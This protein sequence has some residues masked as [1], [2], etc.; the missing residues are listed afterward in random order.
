LLRP[1]G[2]EFH[3]MGQIIEH[4]G[5]RQPGW[6]A[7]GKMTDRIRRYR[8]DLWEL[9]FDAGWEVSADAALAHG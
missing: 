6:A 8:P 4:H 1:L 7:L 3:P 2:I 5:L 9:A